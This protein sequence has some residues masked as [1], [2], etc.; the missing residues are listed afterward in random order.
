MQSNTIN[1][2][3]VEDNTADARL[4]E[5]A[6]A[7][8]EDFQFNVKHA[9][10]LSQALALSGEVSCDAVLLDLTLPDSHGLQTLIQFKAANPALPIIVLSGQQDEAIAIEA[11]KAGAQDYL[12][13]GLENGYLI[14]RAVRYAIERKYS[15][16]A[17]RQARDDLELRVAERT[18]ELLQTN[19]RLQA[20]IAERKKTQAALQQSEARYRMLINTIP[21]GIQENDA[22]G[23]ITFSN[24]AHQKSL[25]FHEEEMI[26]KAIWELLASETDKASL[27]EYLA[28]L[29]KEQPQPTPYFALD[30]TRDG[31]LIDVQVD[32]NYKR[33]EQGSVVGFVSVITDITERKRAEKAIQESETQL[34]LI[35]DALPV[36]ISYIDKNERYQFNNK[37]YEDW[38]GYPRDQLQGKHI[39]D[40]YGETVY[41]LKRDYI[42]RAL[43]GTEVKFETEAPYPQGGTRFIHA[44]YIPDES[45]EGEI[46]GFYKLVRDITE[47]KQAEIQQRQH[48]LQVA[49]VSRLNTTGEMATEIAHEINQPLTAIA[50]YSDACWRMLQEDKLERE[51]LSMALQQIAAQAKRAGEVIRQLRNFIR[52]EDSHRSTIN[53]NVLIQEIVQL[54][55]VEAHWHNVDVQLQLA[56]TMPTV[57]ANRILIQQVL[58][59]FVRNAIDAMA[60]FSEGMRC[61]TITTRVNDD[62]VV[63][64]AV[65]DTGPGLPADKADKVFEPFYTTKTDGIGMG[66]SISESI[67]KSH[68]GKLWAS[69]NDTGGCTFAFSLPI[70][71]WEPRT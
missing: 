61:M 53:I 31:S 10:R 56:E 24:I 13:K 33:D 3:L 47:Q 37:A 55:E 7:E 29:V 15:E 17:L 48:L 49:H 54:I 23:I 20:E 40:V 19:Q 36:L 71:D 39:K 62:G 67:I 32:W 68:N 65:H 18:A 43:C 5:L 27:R 34:R 4:V 35:T 50:T 38:F 63:E 64:V 69:N 9:G 21:H 41:N 14:S 46:R 30:R 25:G 2:L 60:E 66:L 26:G 22:S 59:N 42:R 6:L 8:I 58:L 52:K 11:V 70:T 51:D 57:I 16:E 12:V 1:L 44:T 28:Y 45:T